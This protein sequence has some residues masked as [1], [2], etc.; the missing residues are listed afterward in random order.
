MEWEDILRQVRERLDRIVS[1]L[2]NVPVERTPREATRAIVNA[3][4]D[5]EQIR[6]MT[7]DLEREV[8]DAIED[9]SDE[10]A[11]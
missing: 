5:L 1:S 8:N 9:A 11:D 2:G 6:R 7:T 10:D 4:D 3:L